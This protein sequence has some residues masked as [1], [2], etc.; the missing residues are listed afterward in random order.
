M[1]LDDCI[2]A[3]SCLID[4][5]WHFNNRMVFTLTSRPDGHHHNFHCDKIEYCT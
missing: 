2:I 1:T 4:D 5:L 3:Y